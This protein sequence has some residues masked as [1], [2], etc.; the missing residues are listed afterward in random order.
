MP[1]PP[2]DQ[3]T[4]I[5]MFNPTTG[6][7]LFTRQRAGLCSTLVGSTTDGGAAFG[8]L[9]ILTSGPCSSGATVSKLAFDDHGDGF[10]YGPDL[11]VTHDSGATWTQNPLQDNVLA[12]EALGS[13]IWMVTSACPPKTGSQSPCAL[14][15]LT[16]VD[17]GRTWVAAITPVDATMNGGSAGAGQSWLIRLS[18]TSAYLASSPP[19]SARGQPTTAP[20]W[21]TSD[22]G[23]TWSPRQVDCGFSALI[24]AISAA[25]D[26]TLVAVCASEPS[27]GSQPKSTVESTDGGLTW[28]ETTACQGARSGTAFNCLANQ[29]LSLGYLGEIDAVSAETVYL[30][31]GRSSLLVTHN[32]GASW[33]P[34]EPL[35][36]DTSDG[37]TRVIFFN[38]SD[39]V[40]LG[41]DG[42]NDDRATIYSTSDGGIVWHSVVPE[43]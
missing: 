14:R 21:F 22:G 5:A 19:L 27:A 31:G 12:V 30:V 32:G 41:D 17:G 43:D 11:F 13:S 16:S 1:P 33:T 42:Q 36:G 38:E 25:P 26:G 9:Q 29:P 3:L 28:T 35:I 37:T 7:G 6:Y 4:E 40:V 8:N 15:L 24:D 18:T 23:Q 34:T 2:P 39:G 10:A 20:L